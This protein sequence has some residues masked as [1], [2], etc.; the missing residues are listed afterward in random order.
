VAN[1]LEHEEATL[2]SYFPELIQLINVWSISQSGV[3]SI[4][5]IHSTLREQSPTK[6]EYHQYAMIAGVWNIIQNNK[7]KEKQVGRGKKR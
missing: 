7:L 2:I 3:G 4:T 6:Q 1:L 5:E